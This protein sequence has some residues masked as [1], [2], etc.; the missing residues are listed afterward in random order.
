MLDLSSRHR[1]IRSGQARSGL[2]RLHLALPSFIRCCKRVLQAYVS[3]VPCG[4]CKSRS[5]YW[6]CCNGYTCMLQASVLNVSA[7]SDGCCTCFVLVLHM[8]HTYV[9]SV[10]FGCCICFTL[11]LQVFYLGVA[12]VSHLCCKCF[13][14]MLHMF[15]TRVSLVFRMYVAS[16]STV[17]NVCCKCYH[18]DVGK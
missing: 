5:E 1:K 12:Y 8:F 7:V 14:R 17:S 9:V 18:I 16:V 11:I 4:C 3:S 15:S 10:L 13:I 6:I 2:L